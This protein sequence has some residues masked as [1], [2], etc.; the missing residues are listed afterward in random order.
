MA[1]TTVYRASLEQVEHAFAM[2]V[3]YYEAV[4]VVVR[5]DRETFRKQYFADGS[6]VWLATIEDEIVGC[7]ALRRLDGRSDAVEIKRLYVRPAYRGKGI[8]DL[9]M[10]ALEEYARD[11]GYAW[12]YLDTAAVM[13][14]AAKFYERHGFQH[15][16]R[17]NDNPQAAIFMRKRLNRKF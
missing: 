7:V 3:E 4:Q 6:G 17:Y 12:L 10:K 11:C 16:G 9:L 14:A 13:V 15:C 5:E 2:V 8:A 1:H